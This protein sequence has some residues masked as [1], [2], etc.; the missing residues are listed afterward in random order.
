L[1]IGIGLG[2]TPS[3]SITKRAVDA[4]TAGVTSVL[5]FSAISITCT[6]YQGRGYLAAVR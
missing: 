5:L 2:L 6:S 3:A 1:A 4:M